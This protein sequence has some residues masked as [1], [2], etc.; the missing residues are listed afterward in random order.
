MALQMLAVGPH[1]PVLAPTVGAVGRRLSLK[2]TPDG[3]FVIGG[4]WPG[5]EDVDARVGTTRTGSIRG[6]IEHSTAILPLLA[7]LP[8]QRAWIGLEAQTPDGVPIIG[9]APDVA[10]LTLALGFCGHG[11]ALSPIVGQLISEQIL[12][13]A[14]SIPLDA[15]ALERFAGAGPDDATFPDWQAG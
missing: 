2:Q 9:P 5:D 13:G 7:R 14:P 6:S 3:S 12:D 10:G 8:L 15:F 4:G 1:A 11:F